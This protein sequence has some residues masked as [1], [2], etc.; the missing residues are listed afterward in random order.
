MDLE[1]LFQF[2]RINSIK[3]F[4]KF[5]S[6]RG[7]AQ[8]SLLLLGK[9]VQVLAQLLGQIG[10]LL[11]RRLQKLEELLHLIFVLLLR[12]LPSRVGLR[13]RERGLIAR[14]LDCF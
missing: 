1:V 13:V 12:T 2:Q 14:D 4:V 9:L 8:V 10:L 7:L 3:F 6:Q 11:V 5:Y